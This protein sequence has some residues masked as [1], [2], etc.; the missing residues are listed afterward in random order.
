MEVPLFLLMVVLLLLT[1]IAVHCEKMTEANDPGDAMAESE[2]LCCDQSTRA[3]ALHYASLEWW[4]NPHEWDDHEAWY[5][6]VP[7]H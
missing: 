7:R 3:D 4:H 6:S 5:R 1:A 2:V